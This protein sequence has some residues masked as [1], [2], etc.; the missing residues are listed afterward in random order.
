MQQLDALLV[1]VDG[2]GPGGEDLSFS[3]EYDAIAEARRA[4]DPSLEQGDWVADLKQADWPAVERLAGELLRTR[5][6]DLRLAGWWAE[7]QVHIHGFEGLA[8]G[9]RLVAGLCDAWWDQLHPLAEDGDQEQRIGNL[10]WLITHSARWLRELPL[11]QSPRGSWGLAQIEA[12]AARGPEAEGPDSDAVDAARRDTPHGFYVRLVE[13]LDECAAA[14]AAMEA[15]VDARLGMDGP[16]FGSLRD[17]LENVRSAG[18][19]FAREAGVLLD[20]AG[21]GDAVTS[22]R[23]QPAVAPAHSAQQG[24][25]GPIA[26]RRDAIARLR[27]V[28][29]WFRRSEPH[30]PVAYLADK[31][32]HWGEMPLHVWLRRVVRDNGTLEQLE[33]LLDSAERAPEDSR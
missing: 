25:A 29:E 23:T 30:S 3:P 1:P 6:K 4:D 15:A 19:R 21:P 12:A 32:A 2:P 18:R 33:D 20:P 8:R 9:Y 16:A 27:E 14:L 7:A 17:T 31:A 11:V 22:A 5:S 10:A 28:A 26:S 13:Q 24:Q